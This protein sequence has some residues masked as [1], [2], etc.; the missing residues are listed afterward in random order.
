MTVQTINIGNVVNDG[1][2]DDLRTAFQKV[3]ANFAE[4]DQGLTVTAA[5]IGETGY[6]IF[7]EKVGNELQFKKLV[8]GSKITINEF[9]N[10]LRISTTINESFERIDTQSGIL[11]ASDSNNISI[12]GG[13][14]TITFVPAG[15]PNTLV[16]DTKLPISNIFQSYDFGP[17]T[18]IFDYNTTFSLAASNVDFGFIRF[19]EGGEELLS[20]NFNLDLGEI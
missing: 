14:E 12:R 3:N 8:E 13:E 1:L 6:G 17:I 15:Q 11:R 16:I 20:S 18:G 4:L 19:N 10:S 7:K 5:N 2:G 9:G